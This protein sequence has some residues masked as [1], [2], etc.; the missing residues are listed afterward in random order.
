[1]DETSWITRVSST[2]PG[3]TKIFVRKQRLIVGDPVSFDSEY[4]GLTS[5]ELVLGALGADIAGGLQ[6]LAKRRRLELDN[7]EVLVEGTLNN[8]MMWLGV[9]GEEGSTAIET[10]SAKVYIGT[11]EEDEIQRLDSDE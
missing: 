8:P 9:I 10:I 1:M 3:T 4:D 2:E 6:A 11:I 7:V 5:L